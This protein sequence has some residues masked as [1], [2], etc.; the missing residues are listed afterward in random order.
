MLGTRAVQA[1]SLH[2]DLWRGKASDLA[3]H[4]QIAAHPVG[5]WWK[6][7][8]GQRRQ[9]DRGRYALL[10]SI[11]ADSLDVDL[12]SEVQAQVIEKEIDILIG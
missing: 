5:G 1:G 2:S 9:N 4:D 10:T 3:R 12:Y 6:S 7:H 8:A 11:E